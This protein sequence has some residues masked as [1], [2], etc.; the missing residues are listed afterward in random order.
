MLRAGGGDMTSVTL[1]I[2]KELKEKMEHFSD[3]NWSAI[4]RQAF[5]QKLRDLEFLQ[6]LKSESEL[7]EEETLALGRKVS[8][9]VAKKY[10]KRCKG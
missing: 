5:M 8:S 10:L 6:E 2:P 1:E 9:A 3:L 7:T 4:A